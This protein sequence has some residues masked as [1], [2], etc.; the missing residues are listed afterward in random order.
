MTLLAFATGTSIFKMHESKLVTFELRPTFLLVS[1]K[2]NYCVLFNFLVEE[3]FSRNN[4]INLH[5]TKNDDACGLWHRRLA[6]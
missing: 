2:E 1:Y 5:A 4:F 3:L 6:T